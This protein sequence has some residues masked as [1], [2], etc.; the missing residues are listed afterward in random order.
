LTAGTASIAARNIPAGVAR[1]VFHIGWL[2]IG[3][4]RTGWLRRGMRHQ[5][6][7]TAGVMWC[8]GRLLKKKYKE[9]RNT[10]APGNRPVF[11]VFLV[12]PVFLFV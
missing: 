3:L 8:T 5:L 11:L 7:H 1:E 12:F 2:G 9:Y 6:D 4:L 10:Q